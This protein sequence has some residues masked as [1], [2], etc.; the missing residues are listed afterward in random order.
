MSIDEEWLKE[1]PDSELSSETMD[2][3][4][5]PQHRPK[6]KSSR[7]GPVTGLPSK[8]EVFSALRC[9]I[10][11]VRVDDSVHDMSV[12]YVE[13]EIVQK[14]VDVYDFIKE[15]PFMYK[16]PYFYHVNSDTKLFLDG[17]TKDVFLEITEEYHPHR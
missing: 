14:M 2:R 9:I 11:L 4:G 6:T 8:D 1:C 3:M 16:N 10:A 5:I 15:C 17:L 13:K 12:A 7:K